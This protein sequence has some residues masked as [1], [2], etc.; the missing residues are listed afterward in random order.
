MTHIQSLGTTV[1]LAIALSLLGTGSVNLTGPV[2]IVI[3]GRTGPY[4]TGTFNPQ[5]I[6]LNLS[7][8]IEIRVDPGQVSIPL[9]PSEGYLTSTRSNEYDN[10][11]SLGN[12]RPRLQIRRRRGYSGVESQL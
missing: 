12:F 1:L 4:Q 9:V 2:A 11:E 7:G 3:F 6:Q 8:N 5:M 10:S